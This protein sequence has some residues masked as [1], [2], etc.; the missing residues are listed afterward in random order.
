MIAQVLYYSLV[1]SSRHAGSTLANMKQDD[2]DDDPIVMRVPVHVRPSDP[3]RPLCVFQYPMRPR[4]RPYNLDGI[5]AGK[6][7][8]QQR[9]V[10]LTLGTEFGPAHN[11]INSD[12]PL[13][14][15]RLA[16]ISADAKTSY[17]IGMLHTDEAGSP[18]AFCLTP[19]DSAVQLRPSFAQIDQA[20][21]AAS[22]DGGT[23]SSQAG[24]DDGLDEEGG[25]DD[26][27][28]DGMDDEDGGGGGATAIAPQFRPAQTEREIEAR[29][30][31]HAFLVE[32][33]EAEP[34]SE[35]TMH[36]AESDASRAVRESC[37]EIVT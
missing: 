10:E 31:S 22:K 20:A 30:S 17:A 9:R 7:R 32:Q 3:Q 34:W 6:V 19:L 23:S 16:S 2:N 1:L 37:F 8:P 27:G 33:R 29:R 24:E 13:T 18:Q 36:S 35:A 4:W 12:A 11:D 14:D 25:D 5:R 28:D 15:I 26:G 21:A